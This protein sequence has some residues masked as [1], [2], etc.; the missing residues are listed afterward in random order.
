[1]LTIIP[2]PTQSLIGMHDALYMS[3]KTQSFL[4]IVIIDNKLLIFLMPIANTIPGLNV[5]IWQLYT[6]DLLTVAHSSTMVLNQTAVIILSSRTF[7]KV[8]LSTPWH[9]G[10]ETHYFSAEYKDLHYSKL[11]AQKLI[12]RRLQGFHTTPQVVMKRKINCSISPPVQSTIPLSPM[13]VDSL[14]CIHVYRFSCKSLA[15]VHK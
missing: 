1:M 8:N 13:I 5:R 7:T 10:E 6:W 3:P 2:N 12:E 14:C 9:T 4:C 15:C 11:F